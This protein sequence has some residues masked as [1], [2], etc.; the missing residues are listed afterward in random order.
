MRIFFS[1]D[2]SAF[3]YNATIKA[4]DDGYENHD[5]VVLRRSL[6][7]QSAGADHGRTR[8]Q[9]LLVPKAGADPRRG[10]RPQ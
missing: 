6:R 10:L 4:K 9:A 1:Q 5:V 8:S 2:T 3:A 7:H